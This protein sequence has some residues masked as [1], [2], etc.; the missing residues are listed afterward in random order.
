MTR[1]LYRLKSMVNFLLLLVVARCTEKFKYFIN[2]YEIILYNFKTQHISTQYYKSCDLKLWQNFDF[3]FQGYTESKTVV[4]RCSVKRVFCEISQNS[5]ENTCARDSFNNVADLR[6][7]TLLKK[8]S[9]AQVFYCEFCEIFRNTFF[10]RTPPVAAP[11]E[12]LKLF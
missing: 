3:S 5:Q 8:E 4:R 1:K 9:V 11:T 6:P 7:A 12:P 10:Y 2:R